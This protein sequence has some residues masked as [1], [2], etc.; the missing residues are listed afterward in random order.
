M[1]RRASAS[2]HGRDR[3]IEQQHRFVETGPV[4]RQPHAGHARQRIH[5]FA[6]A[7]HG[8]SAATRAR[9]FGPSSDM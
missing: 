7:L 8:T 3:A 9:P 6:R 5:Q 1:P 4:E 2:Q